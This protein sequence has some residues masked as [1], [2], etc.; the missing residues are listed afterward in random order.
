[1]KWLDFW[2]RLEEWYEGFLSRQ[3]AATN[4]ATTAPIPVHLIK[5]TIEP[6]MTNA[7]K[8]YNAAKADLGL[9]ETLNANVP[10][11][12]GCAQAWSAIARQAEIEGIP[13]EGFSSTNQVDAFCASNEQFELITEPEVGA[14]IVSASTLN[15]HGHVGSFAMF[16]LQYN[17]DWGILSNDSNTGTIRE[18]WSYK[19]WIA[20]YQNTL[21]L[22]IHIYRW[23]T[24]Q[25][26]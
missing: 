14:T 16:D 8:F 22:A 1:M 12:V 11:E 10:I 7:Q 26:Y 18:Q 3:N 25:S 4:V 24:P 15:Q 2:K 13:T 19:E 6:V 21:G 5:P 9:H 23:K 20:Y 17:N